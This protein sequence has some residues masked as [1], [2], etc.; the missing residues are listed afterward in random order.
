MNIIGCV[1]MLNK[2]DGLPFSDRDIKI[3][4]LFNVIS[5]IALGNAQSS[6]PQAA[7]GL[8]R[9]LRAVLE[10]PQASTLSEI[11][12][13]VLRHS[14]EALGATSASFFLVDDKELVCVAPTKN[15]FG[16]EASAVSPVIA[17][18]SNVLVN[19]GLSEPDLSDSALIETTS[20]LAVPVTKA[21]LTAGVLIVHNKPTGFLESDSVL[22]SAFASLA[23]L[24]LEFDRLNRLVFAPAELDLDR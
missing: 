12:S 17:S 13:V 8:D 4:Q 14:A 2:D 24:G 11:V 20:F 10:L 6:R 1:Q 3:V 19:S 23:S 7:T 5:G 15:R 9:L 18:R 21:D 22:L 16:W